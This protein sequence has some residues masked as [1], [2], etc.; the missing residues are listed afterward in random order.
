MKSVTFLYPVHCQRAVV[1]AV[2]QPTITPGNSPIFLKM[3][4]LL[5]RT[6]FSGYGA[7]TC[8]A[9]GENCPVTSPRDAYQ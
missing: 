3:Q 9:G 5:V 7:S 6:L 2:S 4:C 8:I 1:Q